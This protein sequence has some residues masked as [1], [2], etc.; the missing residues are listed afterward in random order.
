[1]EPHKPVSLSKKN[2]QINKQ[3]DRIHDYQK[4]KGNIIA[5]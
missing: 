2:K 5:A 3:K 4:H 1:M